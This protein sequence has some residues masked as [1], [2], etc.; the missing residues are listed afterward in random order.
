MRRRVLVVLIAVA[1]LWLGVVAIVRGRVW[2][3]V[4][5]I[6]LA[7][8][9]GSLLFQSLRPRKPQPSIRLN[10]EDDRTLADRSDEHG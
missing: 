10:L 4:C 1:A 3:G 5:F 8:L 2:L 6:G 9:R 7:V